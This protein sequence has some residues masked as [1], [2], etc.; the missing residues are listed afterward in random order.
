MCKPVLSMSFDQDDTSDS[1]NM[2]S[3]TC[4][5]YDPTLVWSG[6]PHKFSHVKFDLESDGLICVHPNQHGEQIACGTANGCI[7][8][9]EVPQYTT[10]SAKHEKKNLVASM[11]DRESKREKLL[12]GMTREQKVRE[13]NSENEEKHENI[14]MEEDN[15]PIA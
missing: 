15:F 14:P 6:R 11:M 5:E 10:F 2:Y 7:H 3:I 8:L 13:K 12:E 9:L 4:I 1:S